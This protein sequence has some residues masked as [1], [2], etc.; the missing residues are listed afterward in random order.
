M[1]RRINC[2][3]KYQVE[4]ATPITQLSKEEW[5]DLIE[6]S[7]DE[8]EKF[9]EENDLQVWYDENNDCYEIPKF[10]LEKRMNELANSDER[11]SN[12]CK[13]LLE[14]SDKDNNF[15]RVEIF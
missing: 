12:F 4:W 1:E 7:E 3:K 14:K 8:Q 9:C 10:L 15:V 13:E 2:A 5:K 11:L 6:L